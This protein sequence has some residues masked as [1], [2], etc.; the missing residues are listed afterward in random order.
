[1]DAGC[2][3]VL[4]HLLTSPLQDRT[5]PFPIVNVNVGKLYNLIVKPAMTI[6]PPCITCKNV[7][8]LPP[9]LP[10]AVWVSWKQFRSRQSWTDV[11]PVGR[12]L[13]G[14]FARKLRSIFCTDSVWWYK[15][16]HSLTCEMLRNIKQK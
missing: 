14:F 1:M 6:T 2:S 13:L 8:V 12:P 3:L 15:I 16:M 7:A 11:I 10:P 4:C 5:G 9:K